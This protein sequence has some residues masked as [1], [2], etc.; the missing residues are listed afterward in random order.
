[1]TIYPNPAKDEF[2]IDFERVP[3]IM[4][5]LEIVSPSGK[6]FRETQWGNQ[7]SHTQCIELNELQK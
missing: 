7:F 6:I 4:D 3:V 1:M 2:C 5:N